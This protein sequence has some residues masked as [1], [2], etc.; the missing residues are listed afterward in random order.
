MKTLIQILYKTPSRLNPNT[1]KLVIQWHGNVI[2]SHMS[3]LDLNPHR[4]WKGNYRVIHHIYLSQHHQTHRRSIIQIWY[5][6]PSRLKPKSWK[7]VIQWHGNASFSHG[8]LLNFKPKRIWTQN[9]RVIHH[10]W[11][12]QHHTTHIRS[13]VQIWYKT[14]SRLKLKSMKTSDTRAWVCNIFIQVSMIFRLTD[15]VVIILQS[16]T[17]YIYSPSS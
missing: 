16:H 10:M 9:Y 8:S 4:I 6:T 3:F 17:S 2:F 5:K 7:L 15:N 1:W 14:T 11:L 12:S 13:L